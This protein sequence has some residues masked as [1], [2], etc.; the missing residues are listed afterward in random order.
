MAFRDIVGHRT[1]VGLLVRSI[2]RGTLPPSLIFAGPSGVGKR[3]ASVSVAQAMNCASPQASGEVP[4]CGTCPACKRIA[5]GVHPDVNIL[6]PGD[7]GAIKIDQVRDVI[8]RAA[9][10]PFE[11]RHRVVIIDQADALVAQAQNALLKTLE[12]PPAASSFLLVTSVPDLLLPTVLSRC[13]RLTFRP[14]DVDDVATVLMRRGR[15]EAEARAVAAT[16]DGSVGL[17][18]EASA[19]E[20]VEA[21][22]LALRALSSVAGTPPGAPGD[23]SRRRVEAAKELLPKAGGA[24]ATDRDQLAGSLRAMSSILRDVALIAAGA[25]GQMLANRDVRPALDRLG[26][27]GGD[28]GRQAF[29]AVD[30]ALVALERNAAAKIVA[31]WVMLQL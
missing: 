2:E 18:L 7:S 17:A 26:A 9:Y 27:Y 31:D 16:A 10:R 11:G 29:V 8:D 15:S 6:E 5:R 28:R 22:D 21:R 30:Q 25:D 13:P 3:L 1:L 12:E 14:L 23:L 19:G 4:G 20:L 24:S